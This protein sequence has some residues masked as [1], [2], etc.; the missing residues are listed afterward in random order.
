MEA[1]N[2]RMEAINKPVPIDMN[3]PQEKEKSMLE[4]ASSRQAQEIQS[5]MIIARRFP[6][7]INKA[8]AQ[9]MESCR[10][11]RLAEEAEYAYPRGNKTITG[12]S[13]RLAEVLAQNWGNIDF[14]TIELEQ[15]YGSSIMMAYCWD[16]ETN[17]RKTKV[18]TV[19]HLRTTRE[20]SYALSDPRD[21]Y[22]MTA[23][24]GARRLRAC[25]LAVIPG[26]IVD[27]AREMCEK[28]LQGAN[29]EPIADRIRIMAD[30]FRELGVSVEMLEA[31][32]GHKLDVTTEQE[33]IGMRK[34]HRSLKDN[35]ASVDQFFHAIS[36]DDRA[37]GGGG[38]TK[39]ESLKQKIRKARKKKTEEGSI[40]VDSE[41]AFVDSAKAFEAF[42]NQI[43]V[44]L[45][46]KAKGQ[47]A[48]HQSSLLDLGFELTTKGWQKKVFSLEEAEKI[49]FEVLSFQSSSDPQKTAD[50]AG[51]LQ[52]EVTLDEKKSLSGRE[53]TG[54]ENGDRYRNT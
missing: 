37:L 46:V 16:L 34:I 47:V 11:V 23:N 18:F 7:D 17:T 15:K 24:Q 8:Y 40:P 25:I 20:E 53:A 9:I 50:Q 12:P 32:L 5:A 21:I 6:R 30:T 3:L 42:E 41:K 19:K 35:M 26:D 45:I 31:R 22:E 54:E 33:L 51:E 28:T 49:K 38:M 10:R 43:P 44:G 36:K 4:V 13:I 14:G 27:A 52:V 39:T 48:S 1:I 29:K 2:K